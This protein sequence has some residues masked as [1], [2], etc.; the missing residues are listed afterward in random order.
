MYII[1]Q[2]KIYCS[3]NTGN[4]IQTKLVFKWEYTIYEKNYVLLLL[5]SNNGRI[6]EDWHFPII[7]FSYMEKVKIFSSV[8]FANFWI[9]RWTM[10]FFIFNDGF[11]FW[12]KQVILFVCKCKVIRESVFPFYI[13]IFFSNKIFVKNRGCT[14][15]SRK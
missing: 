7:P 9:H 13:S 8:Y 14:F 11:F 5:H 10:C 1:V 2:R 15:L 4:L 6:I 3:L 12:R